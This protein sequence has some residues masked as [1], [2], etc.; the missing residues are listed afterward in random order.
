M[1]SRKRTMSIFGSP[2]EYPPRR[3]LAGR[4]LMYRSKSCRIWRMADLKP[5]TPPWEG[6]GGHE[7]G[8]GVPDGRDGLGEQ[9]VAAGISLAEF[10]HGL[11]PCTSPGRRGPSRWADS[12]T[13]EP[14]GLPPIA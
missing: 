11:L 6:D 10:G 8:V 1:F 14:G 3:V 4:R 9:G 12:G 2:F 7:G 13:P 5:F